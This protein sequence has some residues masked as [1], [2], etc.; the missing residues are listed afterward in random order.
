MR[1]VWRVRSTA[2]R[3]VFVNASAIRD[4]GGR[5]SRFSRCGTWKPTSH[6]RPLRQRNHPLPHGH[7]RDDVIDEVCRGVTYVMQRCALRMMVGSGSRQD[8]YP[9][10]LAS[11]RVHRIA[12]FGTP[13]DSHDLARSSMAGSSSGQSWSVDG[14]KSAPFGQTRV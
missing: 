12:W 11:S 3:P 8:D 13:A 14:S 7:R 9:Y 4:P 10:R 1:W 5:A 2:R 6:P